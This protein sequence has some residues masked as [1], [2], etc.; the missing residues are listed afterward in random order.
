MLGPFPAAFMPQS[1]CKHPQIQKVFLS[2]DVSFLCAG[3]ISWYH[4]S[5]AE[6]KLPCTSPS[7]LSNSGLFCHLPRA[8][9]PLPCPWFIATPLDSQA[10]T[11]SPP[12]WCCNDAPR[13]PG[14]WDLHGPFCWL[15]QQ[16]STQGRQ[17]PDRC[18]SFDVTLS[19]Y[20][21]TKRPFV[22]VRSVL[23]LSSV[24]THS[25]DLSLSVTHIK[26]QDC[27]YSKY[28]LSCLIEIKTHS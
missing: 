8:P 24:T 22:P 7:F 12:A 19:F 4:A 21:K 15:E 13:F 10:D 5:W 27:N 1:I 28:G 9:A 26:H 25:L 16:H 23:S 14:C 18:R 11:V 3:K 20:L 17:I 6:K 2:Y